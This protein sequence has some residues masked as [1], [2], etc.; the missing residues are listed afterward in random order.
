LEDSSSDF[1]RLVS[2]DGCCRFVR[3]L[4]AGLRTRSM[5][6]AS[7]PFGRS[8][9]VNNICIILWSSSWDANL[10]HFAQRLYSRIPA[11]TLKFRV[12][13]QCSGIAKS[14]CDAQVQC[15]AKE[16]AL[17]IRDDFQ[18][19]NRPPNGEE[20]D[21]TNR[22]EDHR[23]GEGHMHVNNSNLQYPTH[24]VKRL[25]KYVAHTPLMGV[26]SHSVDMMLV[27]EKVARLDV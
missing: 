19:S 13:Q 17:S 15:R 4:W 25:V 12:R 24:Y 3:G 6:R 8:T 21:S 18:S 1:T 23:G 14:Y 7:K 10:E 5:R 27:S 20:L 22:K 11:Y 26:I 16:Y 9:A 2:K